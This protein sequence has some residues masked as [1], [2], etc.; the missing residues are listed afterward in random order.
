M[1]GAKCF[2]CGFVGW[3]DAETCK[4]CGAPTADSAGVRYE[5]QPVSGYDQPGEWTPMYG[6]VKKGLA[7]T[8]LVLGVLGFF[9]IGLLGVG[10]VVGIVLAIVAI[11]KANRNPEEYGGKGLATAG[12]IT[13][14]LSLVII[15]PVGIIAAIAIPNLLASR[16]AANEGA[17]IQALRTIHSAQATYQSIHESYATLDEL[18]ADKLIAADL[19]NGK[20]SGYKYQINLSSDDVSKPAGFEVVVVPES[21]PMSGRRSFYLDESG[22]IRGAD[23]QGA[24]ATKYDAPINFNSYSSGPSSSRTYPPGSR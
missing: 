16:R 21:Y 22:V 11:N 15:V 1:N 13:N 18:G 5:P 12:L 19:A 9:T 6:D 23:A 7:V 14:I 24:A 3:A 17:T 8:S 2:E 4:K 10:A 20:R